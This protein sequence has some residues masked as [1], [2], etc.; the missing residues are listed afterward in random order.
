MSFR[1]VNYII[2]ESNNKYIT[3]WE[4]TRFICYVNSL[5]AGNENYERPSDMFS[6]PWEKIEQEEDT[7]DPEII[8]QELLE[9][10]M[11]CQF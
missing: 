10:A 5:I 2:K 9:M 7:R 11:N 8:K 4:Q 3:G 6:F 1:E